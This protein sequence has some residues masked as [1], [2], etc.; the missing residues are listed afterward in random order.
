MEGL[1][2]E[3]FEFVFL[4]KNLLKVHV[5]LKNLLKVHVLLKNLLKSTL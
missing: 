2:V 5:L 4:L 3:F 1:G